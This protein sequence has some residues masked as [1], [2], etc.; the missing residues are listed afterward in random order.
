V[1]VLGRAVARVAYGVPW[2]EELAPPHIEALLIAAARQ[3]VP[4]YAA[5]DIDVLAGKLVTQYETGV[6]RALSR[7][8]KKLLEEL[9]P[10]IAA[11]QGRLMP[12]EPFV[13]ALARAELRGAYLL[14]GDLLAVIDELRAMDVALHRATETPGPPALA[15][16]LEHPYAGDVVRFAMTSE[17]TALRRRVGSAWTG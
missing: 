17:A 13:A 5:D 6:A 8:Q 11:P 4:G 14:G 7:R 3:V 15:A 16:V 12:I 9:S 1:A 2:L 10:H